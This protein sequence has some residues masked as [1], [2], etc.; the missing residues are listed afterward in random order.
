MSFSK[1]I[2]GAPE[3][4]VAIYSYLLH[5]QWELFQ[6]P[7]FAG[8]NDAN[9]YDVILHC[10]KATFGD[11]IIAILAFLLASALVR[12]RRWMLEKNFVAIGAFLFTGILITLGFELLATGTLNRWEYADTMPIIPLLG[13][14]V[15][16]VVQWVLIPMLV[17]W[18]SRRQLR[19]ND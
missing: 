10:T 6:L 19:G 18:F 7:L 4:H 14:G 15:S 11:I 3:V 9:Y 12:S 5:F 16:P 13:V 1:A 8:F 17:I 2:F